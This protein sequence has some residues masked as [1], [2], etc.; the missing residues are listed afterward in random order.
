MSTRHPV[1]LPAGRIRN[2]GGLLALLARNR[3]QLIG[4]TLIAVI[5]PIAFRGAFGLYLDPRPLGTSANTLI[6]TFLAMLFGAY[7]LRRMSAYPGSNPLAAIFP[8]FLASYGV[9]IVFF[10]FLRLDY[11]RSQFIA[12]FALVVLWFVFIGIIEPRLRRQKLLL[13]PSGRTFDLLSETGADWVA[14]SSADDATPG[15]TGVVADFNAP[16]GA[17]WER[18][19][20]RSALAGIPVYHWKQVA[21]SLS[22]RVQI[23]HLAE[24]TLGSSLPSSIYLRFKRLGDLLLAIVFAPFAAI[25]AVVTAI[26]IKMEDGGPVIFRQERIGFRGEPF[27]MLKFRS[28]KP[29]EGGSAFTAVNDDRITAVGHLLRRFRIDELPQIVN[30]LRGEMSWIGPRP[31]PNVV[32]ERYEALVP[33]YAYRHIVRPGLTGWAQVHQGY[34]AEEGATGK[35]QYDF[36]YIKYFSP[37]LD[38]VILAKTVHT[39]VSGHG[40][41]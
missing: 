21:E 15:I 30:V 34:V 16:M 20:A 23:E 13:L 26:A 35:L 3:F 17:E 25:V 32:A 31:E 5:L 36:F 38:L 10:F 4:A 2:R 7:L 28:M 29:Q 27:T 1:A 39:I 11:S 41:R 8:A 12:S 19:L 22:G 9:V 33:F 37:W 6:G 40:S 18:L 14:A 24:N